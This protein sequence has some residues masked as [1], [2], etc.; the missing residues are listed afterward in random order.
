MYLDPQSRGGWAVEALHAFR[1]GMR[2]DLP[3]SGLA[4]FAMNDRE[5]IFDYRETDSPRAALLNRSCRAID[6]KDEGLL[7]LRQRHVQRD[8]PR[9]V[10]CNLIAR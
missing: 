8:S 4:L 7:E 10:Q 1:P 9:V 3:R 2:A 5:A 6:Y